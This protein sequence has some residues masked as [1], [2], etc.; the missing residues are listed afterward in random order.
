MQCNKASVWCKGNNLHVTEAHK[1]TCTC[2]HSIAV[3]RDLS[4]HR[5]CSSGGRHSR[6]RVERAFML[7][8]LFETIHLYFGHPLI[9]EAYSF[10]S[11]NKFSS[12]CS[13]SCCSSMHIRGLDII[14]ESGYHSR[15]CT[16]PLLIASHYSLFCTALV[17]Q[18]SL[19]SIP[20]IIVLHFQNPLGSNSFPPLPK[21]ILLFQKNTF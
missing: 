9:F 14:L 20:S 6:F 2:K 8:A 1:G 13:Q 16:L 4:V 11:L 5:T 19:V 15:V 10:V 21:L 12:P 7:H 18:I 17:L 3:Y